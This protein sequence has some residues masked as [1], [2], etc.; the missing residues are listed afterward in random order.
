MKQFLKWTSIATLLV[1]LVGCSASGPK[2]AEVKSTMP[3]L[4]DGNGRIVFYRNDSLMGAALQPNIKLNGNVV[5]NS[6]PGGFFYVDMPA[7]DYEVT[8]STEVEKKLTFVLEKKQQKCVRTSIGI[9]ILVGRV[10][11]ELTEPD[12]CDLELK[13]L[14]YT[15]GAAK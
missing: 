6:V 5:G 4:A 15:G 13:T 14:S 3:V 12:V 10:Y 1:G 11:P 9:G 8:T 2:Y 7:A